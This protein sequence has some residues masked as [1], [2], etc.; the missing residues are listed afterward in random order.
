MSL[1]KAVVM[2][3]VTRNPEK[4]FTT[5]NL[6]ITNIALN[7]SDKEEEELVKVVVVGK[8]A[9]TAESYTKG[10]KVI[11]E[12]RLQT[13]VVKSTDGEEKK[14]FEISA[15]AIEPVGAGTSNQSVD[16][17]SDYLFEEQ[18][19]ADDLIGEDEIPF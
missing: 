6:A 12:G 18:D 14:I 5:N 11:V 16:S 9:E 15:Q 10:T 4:R 3:T 2:G 8:L 17:G 19:V 7:I 13:N 1:S